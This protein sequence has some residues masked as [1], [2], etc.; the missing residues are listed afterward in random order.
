MKTVTEKTQ[1][2]EKQNKGKRQ[3]V[4]QVISNK[5]MNTVTVKV[6]NSKL[7]PLYKKV[8]RQFRRYLADTNNMQFEPGDT[9]RIMECKPFSKNKTWIVVE[10]INS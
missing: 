10:K 9:V 7:H 8:V 3:L 1:I 2:K 4:G 6:I 5:M